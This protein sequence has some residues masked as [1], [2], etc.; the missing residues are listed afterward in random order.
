M[1]IQE[2]IVAKIRERVEARGLQLVEAWSYSNC[3]ELLVQSPKELETHF[4]I[5]VMFNSDYMTTGIAFGSESIVNGYPDT[6]KDR[7]RSF[8]IKYPDN[9][10][11]N[12]FLNC[13]AATLNRT[14]STPD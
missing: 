14:L 2:K 1:R 11:M 5:P 7:T 4:R 13:L 8:F 10:E 6:D 9:T 12:A 3:G